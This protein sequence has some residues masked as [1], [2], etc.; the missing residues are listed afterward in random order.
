M[1]E[2]RL[3]SKDQQSRTGGRP[4]PLS[5]EAR[6]ARGGDAGYIT[7]EDIRRNAARPT[8]MRP[9]PSGTGAPEGGATATH[10]EQG[11]DA[12]QRLD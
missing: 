11:V 7:A 10:R 6:G 5:G 9:A 4:E 2:D 1:S 12:G 8:G 3:E